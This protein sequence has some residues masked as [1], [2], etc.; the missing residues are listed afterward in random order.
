M[1]VYYSTDLRWRAVWLVT[2]H[3]MTYEEVSKLVRGLLGDRLTI[4]S[5]LEM[6]IQKNKDMDPNV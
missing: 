2:L 6:L 4:F 5:P 1:P 3:G